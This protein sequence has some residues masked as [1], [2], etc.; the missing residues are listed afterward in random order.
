MPTGRGASAR[1]APRAGPE[2]AVERCDPHKILRV[3]L[4]SADFDRH[5]VGYLIEPLLAAA[6]PASLHFFC[7]S[8]RQ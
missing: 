2:V 8:G 1:Q 7:Y 4:V 5:P 3:G 6:D